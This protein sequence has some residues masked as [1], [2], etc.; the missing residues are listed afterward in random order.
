MAVEKSRDTTFIE[1]AGRWPN[2]VFERH[3][4]VPASSRI[5]QHPFI[6]KLIREGG[7]VYR[8]IAE[9]PAAKRSA[10]HRCPVGVFDIDCEGDLEEARLQAVALCDS[11]GN[12]LDISEHDIWVA[13]SG[14]KGFHVM[15]SDQLFGGVAYQ[16]TI[17]TWRHVAAELQ[18]EVA[19]SIDPA[20]Y[21]QGS[22]IR[23]PNTVNRKSGQFDIP[24]ETAE[25]K[26]MSSNAICEL[27]I[28][29]RAFNPWT[30][31]EMS[32][33]A[34]AWLRDRIADS[35]PQCPP[36]PSRSKTRQ[37]HHH[38]WHTP[39]CVRRAEREVIKDGGRH[40]TYHSLARF[41][42]SVGMAADEI[43]DRLFEIDARHP[44]RDPDY[45]P[46]TVECVVKKPGFR[47]CPNPG[48]EPLCEPAAC[49]LK[50]LSNRCQKK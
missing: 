21:R 9:Y 17:S 32:E 27:A 15:L 10:E 22:L 44:I 11:L 5:R 19:G 25:L 6:Q 18:R 14:S 1:L 2:K 37:P 38:G 8:S 13:F 16:A 48:L 49:P 45:I 4:F 35:E 12:Q 42:F 3:R 30:S 47:S 40:A 41:Y 34:A 23:L 36:Q 50:R 31:P 24:L 28:K 43:V 39:P 26:A 20:I 33:Q 46:R 7:D 29:P